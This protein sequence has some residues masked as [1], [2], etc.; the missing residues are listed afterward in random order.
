VLRGVVQVSTKRFEWNTEITCILK[1]IYDGAVFG[2]TGDFENM[3]DN[4]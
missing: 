1:S 2:E 4:I 3:D